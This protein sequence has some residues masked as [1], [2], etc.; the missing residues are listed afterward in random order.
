MKQMI[1]TG[2]GAW[3]TVCT[4]WILVL[5][6]LLAGGCRESSESRLRT[7]VDSF[8]VAYFNWNLERAAAFATEE[9]RSWL[10]YAAS[11]VHQEEVDLL[12]GMDEGAGCELGDISYPADS[13]ALGEVRVRHFV[14]IDTLGRP[15]RLVEKAVYRLPAVFRGGRWR[16]HLSALPRAEKE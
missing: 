2:A 4:V 11:Q 1:S 3:S 7:E 14:G 6:A 9:S 10:A 13:M 12:R 5:A 16:V 15:G 8:A